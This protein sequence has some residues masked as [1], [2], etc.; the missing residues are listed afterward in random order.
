MWNF[1]NSAARTQ[2]FVIY[3]CSM[4]TNVCKDKTQY[5][6]LEVNICLMFAKTVLSVKNV[7]VW[8][9]LWSYKLDAKSNYHN[10]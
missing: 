5:N 2:T 8:L 6:C 7:C 9:G 10:F 1:R 4:F 3:G